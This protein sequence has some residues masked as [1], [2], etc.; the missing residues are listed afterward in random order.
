[1][2]VCTYIL[3]NLKEEKHNYG[4]NNI[5]LGVIKSMGRVIKLHHICN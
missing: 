3:L 2:L 4:T 5:G 1:M